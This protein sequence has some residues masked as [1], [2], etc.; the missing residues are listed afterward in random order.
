MRIA[1]MG[2]EIP[3]KKVILSGELNAATAD[4]L[5]G[6]FFTLAS[7][8]G[9]KGNGSSYHFPIS[10]LSRTCDWDLRMV[11]MG[12]FR[13]A[14]LAVPGDVSVPVGLSQPA[15]DQGV[16][17]LTLKR[18][19]PVEG[20]HLLSVVVFSPSDAQVLGHLTIRV[21][22]ARE[23]SAQPTTL[24]IPL[25]KRSGSDVRV[26]AYWDQTPMTIQ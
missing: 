17:T 2:G 5:K 20:A 6:D 22:P 25:N 10:L 21:D 13:G 7:C 8:L 11:G 18:L 23:N 24:E 16:Y 15:R 12:T 19:A 9:L 3:F 26:Q 4:F 1:A 14:A